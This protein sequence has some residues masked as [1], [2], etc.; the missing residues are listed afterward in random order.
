MKISNAV[1]VAVDGVS[2]KT[3]SPAEA[4]RNIA[5]AIY[6]AIVEYRTIGELTTHD[7]EMVTDVCDLL[8][9]KLTFGNG[10]VVGRIGKEGVNGTVL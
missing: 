5:K 3:I 9:M 7:K 8:G 10:R 6:E 2:T 1:S 4:K